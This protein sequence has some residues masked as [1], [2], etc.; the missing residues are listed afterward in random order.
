MDSFLDESKNTDLIRWSDKGDS[1]VVLDEDEFAKTLIP[2]LFKHNNYASFVRQLNMY[3]FHKRVGLSDNSMKASERKNKSPSEYYNPYFKRG[4][5]NLLW[6]INKP[7]GG[8]GKKAAKSSKREEGDGDSE[9]DVVADESLAAQPI[10]NAG[11]AGSRGITAAEVSPLPKKDL[12]QVKSQLETLQQQQR[13]ISQLIERLRRDHNQLVNQALM[14]QNMHERHENSINAILN[15]LANVFRKSLEEQGGAQSVSDLLASIIP[16]SQQMPQGSVVDLGDFVRQQARDAAAATTPA[17]RQPRLLPP[18]PNQT[19]TGPAKAAPSSTSSQ[20]SFQAPQ[21]QQQPMGSVT[22]VF[23]AS[24][25]DTSSPSYIKNDLRTNPQQRMMQIIQDTNAGGGTSGIDLPDVAA[26][27]PATMSHEQRSKMLNIMAG[28]ASSSGSATPVQAQAPAATNRPT[29]APPAPPMPPAPA[30]AETSAS[31]N[32]SLSPVFPE[33]QP[34]SIYEIRHTQ[35]EID[36]LQQMQ[37]DQAA[38]L[39]ELSNLLGPLSPSGRIPGVDET[40]NPP[41]YFDNIDF[42]SFLEPSALNDLNYNGDF[43]GGTAGNTD[44][45]DFN[46]SLD[47]PNDATTSGVQG[48]AD[49]SGSVPGRVVEY[50]SGNNT[51]SPA[52]TE[53]IQRNDFGTPE[54]DTKRRRKF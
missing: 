36:A 4:H 1:F 6:L 34:P 29:S 20:A 24:P 37:I 3:G 15:F 35:D 31:P 28:Q 41:G 30:K 32:M 13:A 54:H 53:E 9:E 18:I 40:G 27:T 42:D 49:G 5:P 7:K 17:K 26:K 2:E 48:Q 11:Q 8:G 12:V 14:F 39:E 50:G 21:Q 19:T 33:M 16:G 38:K 22:E 44:G 43:S 25:S 45:N 10:S 47:A 51:P 52:G 23:D 46:F